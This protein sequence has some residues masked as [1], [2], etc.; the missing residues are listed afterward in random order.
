M[1]LNIRP[2]AADQGKVFDV[3]DPD[4]HGKILQAGPE[5][6][7]VAFDNGAVRN[8][9]NAHLRPVETTK[10]E[11]ELCQ[12]NPSP[13]SEIVRLGQEAM[14]RKRRAWADWLAIA[15]ALQAGRAEVMR[16]LPTNEPRGRRYEKAM[17]DW[18]IANSFKEIDKGARK[19]LFDC[20]EHRTEIEKWRAR[21]TDAERFKFNH[22]DTVLRKWKASTVVPDS[23]APPK[24]SPYQKLQADHMALIEERDRYKREVERNG[25]DLWTPEDTPKAIAKIML[26]KLS[27]SKAEKVARE[28]LKALKVVAT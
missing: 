11:D 8:I 5:V 17:A 16:A 23:N 13:V 4:L 10:A 28:I 22:P 3:A 1:P 18:L 21:L 19:R 14:A 15:E 9:G 26:G 7:E 27:K 24:V 20:L 12:H 2:S 25:G 6:S